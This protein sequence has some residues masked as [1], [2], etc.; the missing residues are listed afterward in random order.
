MFK[1]IIIALVFAGIAASNLYNSGSFNVTNSHHFA[2]LGD[3]TFNIAM[4]NTDGLGGNNGG[5]NGGSGNGG[6][7]GGSGGG[8]A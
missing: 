3:G 7:S 4:T 5:G 2:G 6:N 1:I 8:N